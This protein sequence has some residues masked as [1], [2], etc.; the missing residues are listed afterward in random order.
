MRHLERLEPCVVG[1]VSRGVAVVLKVE[2]HLF[3]RAREE[4]WVD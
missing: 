2:L 3:D 1:T 4:L